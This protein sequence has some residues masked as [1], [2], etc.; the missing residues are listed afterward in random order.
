MPEV[1]RL[2]GVIEKKLNHM[3]RRMMRIAGLTPPQY[4][5]L[6]M[7]WERDER[8]LK[9]LADGCQCTRATVT[10]IADT[11]ERKG[12]ITREP[13]PSDRRS[14]L[15][16]LTEKGRAIQKNAPSPELMFGACCTCLEPG[17]ARQLIELLNK[18]S[19]GLVC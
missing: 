15:A 7:L 14:I 10:G 12:L 11:L 18:L 16:K 17:E 8:P 4:A 5:A 6:S 13:N 3:Q 1:F 2:I 9:E 19:D